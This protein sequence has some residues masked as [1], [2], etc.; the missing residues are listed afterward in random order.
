MKYT[1][2]KQEDSIK[3]IMKHA[4]T[5]RAALAVP[6]MLDHGEAMKLIVADLVAKYHHNAKRNDLEWTPV[7][8]KVLSYYLSPE[9]LDALTKP[10]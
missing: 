2:T 5:L 8:K 1:V 10:H 4:R 9:E 3:E 6:V 7:F